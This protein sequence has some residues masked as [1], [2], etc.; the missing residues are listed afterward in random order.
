VTERP[1]VLIVDDDTAV[2]QFMQKSLEGSHFRVTAVVRS[3]AA[4][5]EAIERRLPALVLIDVALEGPID[6]IALAEQVRDRWSLPVVYVTGTGDGPLFER[7]V[8]SEPHGYVSKPFDEAQLRGAADLALAVADRER[9][10]MRELEAVRG[11]ASELQASASVMEGRL[12]QIADVLRDA[13]VV[14]LDLHPG[15]SPEIS[16]RI[17]EMSRRELEVLQLLLSSRRVSSIARELSISAYTVRNHLR[18]VFRKLNVHSQTE[19][20]ELFRGISPSAMM[21]AMRPS[22]RV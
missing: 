17:G 21:T 14:K 11:Y 16:A 13:G 5:V 6:G 12:G 8:K 7:L 15:L 19:L 1:E 4:A 2:G 22:E 18:A 3:A 9:R 20:L 10:R